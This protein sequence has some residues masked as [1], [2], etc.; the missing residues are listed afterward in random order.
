VPR[1]DFAYL[2]S[3]C[4]RISAGDFPSVFR[5]ITSRVMFRQMSQPAPCDVKVTVPA[6]ARLM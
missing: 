6:A 5:R 3:I 2:P 4:R 1:P